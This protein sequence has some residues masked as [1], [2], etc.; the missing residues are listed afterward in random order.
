MVLSH[1]GQKHALFLYVI[2]YHLYAGSSEDILAVITDELSQQQEA[3][4]NAMEGCCKARLKD[5][6]LCHRIL[7]YLQ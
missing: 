1:L 7:P 5:R 2:G 3:Q 6:F 4:L